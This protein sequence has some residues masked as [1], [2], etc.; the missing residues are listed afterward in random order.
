MTGKR[1]RCVHNTKAKPQSN[2]AKQETSQLTNAD[3]DDSDVIPPTPEVQE[4]PENSATKKTLSMHNHPEKIIICIDRTQDDEFTKFYP[5]SG[6]PYTPLHMLKRAVTM[7]LHNKFFI[8]QKHQYALVTLQENTSKWLHGFTS[9]IQS[10]MQEL[11]KIDPCH[12]EDIFNLNSLF[13]A[14]LD[15]M[16]VPEGFWEPPQTTFRVVLLYNRSYTLPEINLD[17]K[18]VEVLNS[19]KFF[20]DILM[21]HEPPDTDNNC[22]KIFDV[23]QGLD[24]KGCGYFFSVGRSMQ[25]LYA[26]MGKLLSHPLQRP[27]QSKAVYTLYGPE[28]IVKNDKMED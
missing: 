3:D 17:D 9:N 6:E 13:E 20:L 24:K 21:T 15:K 7:F 10:I 23:L 16:H 2:K 25:E 26:S 1:R 8:D 19:S 5:A 14:I 12:A 11:N 4:T 22:Q 27:L 28:N 18:L